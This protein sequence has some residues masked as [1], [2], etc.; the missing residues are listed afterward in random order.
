MLTN[1][2][3]TAPLYGPY[4]YIV[5]I[6]A[7]R[8]G[9]VPCQ[10]LSY[11]KHWPSLRSS[12]RWRKS[13]SMDERVEAH[14]RALSNKLNPAFESTSHSCPPLNEY[15]IQGSFTFMFEMSYTSVSGPSR[16]SVDDCAVST[17]MINRRLPC[18]IRRENNSDQHGHG[19][20][21]A[22]LHKFVK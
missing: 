20:I 22:P 8:S 11:G 12:S 13:S 1:R 17:F 10:L 16:N 2:L 7:H 3:L 5:N 9:L 14:V 15:R 19:Q 6:A 21:Q 4:S 18:S